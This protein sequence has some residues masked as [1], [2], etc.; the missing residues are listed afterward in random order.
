MKTALIDNWT[1]ER[2]VTNKNSSEDISQELQMLISALV[3]WD[4]VCYLDNGC[5]EWW[6][7][8][9]CDSEFKSLVQRIKSV[10]Y[11]EKYSSIKNAEKLYLDEY[12]SNNTEVVAKGALEYL[13]FAD[14]KNMC[15]MPFGE[16]A[17]FIRNNNLFKAFGRHYT[18]IDTIAEVDRYIEEYFNRANNIIKN[19]EFKIPTN[20]V[21]DYIKQHA[22][23]VEEM[24][25][26][27]DDLRNEKMLKNYK[28]WMHEME[29][30]IASEKRTEKSLNT[31]LECVNQL[32]EIVNTQQSIF[33]FKTPILNFF[34]IDLTVTLTSN[35]DYKANLAFPA[36][37]YKH[38]IG[39]EDKRQ[40]SVKIN[41]IS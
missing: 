15:Y 4:E 13:Y 29:T 11:D 1:I 7:L 32:K 10:G 2:I 33:N 38:A 27:I 28:K 36:T 16:R 40:V 6:N 31:I 3:L 9:V 37:L 19:A 20:S 22:D 12:K 17:D 39:M 24:V 23:T 18:R 21:Y 41:G 25:H 5:S 30:T 26:V 35:K 8:W 14:E 34:N